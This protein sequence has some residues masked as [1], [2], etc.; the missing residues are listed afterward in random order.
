MTV[1]RDW[2]GHVGRFSDLEVLRA[3]AAYEAWQANIEYRCDWSLLKKWTDLSSED[4]EN[5]IFAAEAAVKTH[6]ELTTIDFIIDNLEN[7]V[8]IAAPTNKD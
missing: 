1:G 7:T 3:K 2:N 4:Q 8:K 6:V 5:W